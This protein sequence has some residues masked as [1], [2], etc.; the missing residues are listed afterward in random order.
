MMPTLYALEGHM[1]LESVYGYVVSLQ[2]NHTINPL[3]M[4][5]SP[6]DALKHHF[7]SLK[8]DLTFLQL[9]VLK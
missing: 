1:P 9:R 6:H 8:T 2:T 3:T 4:P 5:L 7:T